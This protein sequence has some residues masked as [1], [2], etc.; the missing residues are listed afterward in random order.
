M[1]SN[2]FVAAA[3]AARRTVPLGLAVVLL[4]SM[5]GASVP[6]RAQDTQDE[7]NAPAPIVRDHRGRSVV[8]APDLPPDPNAPPPIVRDHRANPE[9]YRPPDPEPVRLPDVRPRII[10]VVALAGSTGQ[11][12]CTEIWNIGEGGAGPFMVAFA[13]DGI[14]PADG[15][16]STPGLLTPGPIE[17]CIETD[18]SVGPHLLA[19]TVDEANT[20]PESDEANNV[21][22][23]QYTWIEPSPGPLPD[24]KP[25][26][27][28]VSDLPGSTKKQ[29]CIG[30]SNI[31]QGDAGPFEVALNVSWVRASTTV[32]GL[33]AG[34]DVEP[35]LEVELELGGLHYLGA[36]VDRYDDRL[37]SDETNNYLEREYTATSSAPV[38][39]PS[40]APILL[41]S[42]SKRKTEGQGQAD[43]AVSAI[44][45][46]GQAPD[47]KND[48]KDGKNDVAVVVKNAG[49]ADARDVSVRLV[50]DDA[51]GAALEQS[52]KGLGAG[53][54]RQVRFEDVRLKKGEH[55]ITASVAGKDT[56][57]DARVDKNQLRVTVRCQ[58]AS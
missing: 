13:V 57:G 58:D 17:P 48:C 20:V 36:I 5:L 50:V 32:P 54:E 21:V 31:G 16:V 26:A 39:G 10:K 1:F 6:A 18:L 15:K 4:T 42:E 41:T 43:L 45:V 37:E 28:R 25:T 38:P 35:C 49:T 8:Y 22:E 30:V 24:L 47:G 33:R 44:R 40:P 9:P 55:Q 14:V 12:V 53:Q 52:V 23:R 46:N 2:R 19:V 56:S 51:Q 7:P 11:R 27:L 3:R 29:T 34:R